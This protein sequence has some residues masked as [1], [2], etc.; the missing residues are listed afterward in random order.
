MR[1]AQSF[2]ALG[3]LASTCT[4]AADL[5]SVAPNNCKILKESDKVRVIEFTARKGDKIGTH[6]HPAHVVYLLKAGKTK[7]TLEDG[8]T[9]MG[10]GKNGDALINPPVT[11]SQE[12]MEAV[13]AI[14]V[15]MKE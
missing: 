4:F 1:N 14:L 7:F 11:H 12:H 9:R 15:E 8:T 2:I 13:H 3:F 5:C 10:G 6:S